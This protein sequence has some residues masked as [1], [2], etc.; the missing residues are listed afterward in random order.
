MAALGL[1]RRPG[2]GLLKSR[3]RRVQ[4]GC[5]AN[6]MKIRFRTLALA[7]IALLVVWYFTGGQDEIAWHQQVRHSRWQGNWASAQLEHWP[8]HGI[9]FFASGIAIY[10][11]LAMIAVRGISMLVKKFSKVRGQ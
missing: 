1:G 6:V 10:I 4:N 9:L 11:V 5:A 7:A 3:D 2:G 8:S